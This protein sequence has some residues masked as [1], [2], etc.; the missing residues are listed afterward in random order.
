[1]EPLQTRPVEI[2]IH[3]YVRIPSDAWPIKRPGRSW[4]LECGKRL[5]LSLQRCPSD[6]RGIRAEL[7][8]KEY[9]E[10]GRDSGL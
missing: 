8:F 4:E 2:E 7:N 10:E 9:L 3:R 5:T 6:H 1:M